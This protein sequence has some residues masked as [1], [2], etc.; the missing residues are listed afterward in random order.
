M[1]E[2]SKLPESCSPH[3][4]G[5]YLRQPRRAPRL[6]NVAKQLPNNCREIAPNDESW[7]RFEQPWPIWTSFWPAMT[8][9][10]QQLVK[11]DQHWSVWAHVWPKL[12]KLFSKLANAILGVSKDAA[13]TTHVFNHSLPEAMANAGSGVPSAHCLVGAPGTEGEEVNSAQA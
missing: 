8:D 3:V 5:G 13:I 10:D 9:F 2:R 6:P 1:A 4:P 12:A 7:P 11:F